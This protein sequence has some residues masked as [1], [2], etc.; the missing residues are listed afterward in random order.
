MAM[1]DRPNILWYCADQMRYDT[2]AALGNPH[3]RTPNLDQLVAGGTAFEKAY[4]Q[5]PVCTPSRASFLTGRYPASHHVYRNGVRTF[6]DDE[7]LVT[8]IL[9]D[10]GYDCGLVGKLHLSTATKGESRVQDGYRFFQWSHHPMTG[11]A[12]HLN[13]YHSW[14]RDEKGVCP[15]ELFA[16]QRGFVAAG[17]PEDLHQTTWCTEM[18]IRFIDEGRDGPWLLSVNP[19]DPHPPFDPPADYLQRYDPNT[20]PP[21]LFRPSDLE[22]QRMFARV[23]SQTVEAVDPTGSA[24]VDGDYKSQSERGYRPPKNFDG[25]AAKA[26]YFAMIELIDA[27]LGRIIQHL[28]AMRELDNTLIVFM[29]D[30]GELL[31]DHG[32]M[33]KG[34]RFFEGLVHVPLILSG[35][36]IQKGLRSR[37]LVELVDVAPTLLAMANEPIPDRMQGCALTNILEGRAS[38]PH[39]HK[40]TVFCDFND[41]VGYSPVPDD[42][43]AT[44]TFDGRY[45]LV[46]YHTHDIGELFDL[47]TDPGEF[48]NLFYDEIYKDLRE[49]LVLRHVNR[50]ARTLD[51]GVER[52]SNA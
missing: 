30:H 33:Y 47:E 46:L 27:Q 11:E 20:I 9:A 5:A 49:Q 2:I 4:A 48:N 52:V 37:A 34:C 12:D 13:A 6:P 8:K 38:D 39:D 3:I 50:F 40:S 32:L 29:S 23:R 44:M 43:Q 36:R 22:R 21:P 51:A 25:R 10:A 45:K 26:A 17:V 16:E 35:P 41:S 19:Y 1:T 15:S 28:D 24:T 42:T 7:V 31:G 14:L 18:A